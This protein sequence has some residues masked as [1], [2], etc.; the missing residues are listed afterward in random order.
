M[1]LTIAYV[2]RDYAIY[3]IAQLEC[4]MADT[5]DGQDGLRV[6]INIFDVW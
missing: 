6:T 3:A 1:C 4:T 2:N 5:T